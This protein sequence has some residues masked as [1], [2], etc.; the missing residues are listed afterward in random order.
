MPLG[1]SDLFLLLVL[2]AWCDG[3]CGVTGGE[4]ARLFGFSTYSLC[5]QKKE[6]W[7]S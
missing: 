2:G 1:P 3:R 5:K 4:G 7:I 6:A